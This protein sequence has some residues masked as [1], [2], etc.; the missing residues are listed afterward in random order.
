MKQNID[1]DL[2]VLGFTM[3]DKDTIRSIALGICLPG[4][5]YL[6]VGSVGT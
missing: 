5:E 6:F 3:Q 2:V 4:D 1:L